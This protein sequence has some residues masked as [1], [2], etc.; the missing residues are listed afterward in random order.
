[1]NVVTDRWLLSTWHCDIKP[2]GEQ[3][4]SVETMAVTSG[5]SDVI[6]SQGEGDGGGGRRQHAVSSITLQSAASIRWN[7][8]VF[9][10]ISPALRSPAERRDDLYLHSTELLTGSRT[11]RRVCRSGDETFSNEPKSL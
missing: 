11:K 9:A 3:I 1:M 4:H 2:T 5:R 8:N 6:S 10:E 7:R